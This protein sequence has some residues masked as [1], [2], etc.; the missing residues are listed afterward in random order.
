MIK[1]ELHFIERALNKFYPFIVGVEFGALSEATKYLWIKLVV[2]A[3]KL[4]EAYPNIKYSAS[5]GQL[6][7]NEHLFQYSYVDDDRLELN[8]IDEDVT[9]LINK[10]RDKLPEST[11]YNANRALYSKI[12]LVP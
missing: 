11:K 8:K 12:I 5:F 4:K 10:I 2:S 3:S 6:I 7:S 1:S 9:I